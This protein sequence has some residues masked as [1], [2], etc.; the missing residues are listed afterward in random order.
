MV[1]LLKQIENNKL[2]IREKILEENI[3]KLR[4]EQLKRRKEVLCLLILQYNTLMYKINMRYKK[5]ATKLQETESKQQVKQNYLN[6]ENPKFSQQHKFTLDQTIKKWMQEKFYDQIF[7]KIND[8]SLKQLLF[9]DL[10]EFEAEAQNTQKTYEQIQNLE[11]YSQLKLKMSIEM[12]KKLNTK[13][14]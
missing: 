8:I 10:Q 7:D 4:N 13:N 11:D 6:D 14:I 3:I 2:K 12:E 9:E 5:F 1:L